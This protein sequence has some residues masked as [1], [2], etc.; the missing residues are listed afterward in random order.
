MPMFRHFD[1]LETVTS[2]S[3]HLKAFVADGVPRITMADEQTAGKGRYGHSWYS[4]K[5]R[6]CMS[7]SWR[8]Q[9]GAQPELPS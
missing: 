3:E 8:T 7:P 5:E 9:S 2:T 1:H 6:V 4:E